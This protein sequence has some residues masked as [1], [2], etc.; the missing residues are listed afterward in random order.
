VGAAGRVRK[1]PLNPVPVVSTPFFKIGIDLIG[2]FSPPSSSGNRFVL[3]IV[4][5]A[6]RFPE[7]V[8]LKHIDS[9]SIAEA[10]LSVF[11]RVGIPKEI[12]TDRG[13]QFTSALMEQFRNLLS[14]NPC[15]TTPYHPQANGLCEKYNGVIKSIIKKLCLDKPKDWDKYISCALFAIRETPIECLGFSPFEMLYGRSVRGP[16]TLIYDLWTEKNS[17]EDKDCFTYILDLRERL[18]NSAEMAKHKG[19]CSQQ[20]SKLY[21]DRRSSDRFFEGGRRGVVAIA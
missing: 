16:L 8:P 9:I 20:R 18:E 1:A 7:A 12:V 11:S 4:D 6:T 17:P 10:L 14:I 13:T 3:T 2:P 21:F 15:F 5:Y 19:I